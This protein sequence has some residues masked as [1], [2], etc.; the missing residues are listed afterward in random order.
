MKFATS[1][2]CMDGRIQ[3]PL[4]NHIK[5]EYDVQFIDCITE[6][7]PCKILSENTERFLKQSIDHRVSIS[8]LEHGSKILFIS[9]HYDCAGN[10][11][12]KN[13]QVEQIK[14]SRK[15]LQL[16]YPDIKVIALWINEKWEV[17]ELKK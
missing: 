10:P 15:Q 1:I 16:K 4:I 13:I 2:R 12:S 7:G 3:E 8:I 14:N 11:V 9:G 5:S 17:E 6:P